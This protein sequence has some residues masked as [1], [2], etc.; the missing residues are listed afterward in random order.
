MQD[1]TVPELHEAVAPVPWMRRWWR[2]QTPGR[3]DRF[4]M[5]APL[6]A[7]LLFLAA[8]I[9][10]FWYLRL[11]EMD[12]EQEAVRRDVEYAQ[13]RLRLRLLERQEQLM[14]IARDISNKEVDPEEFIGR[15]ESMVIQ[16][17]ELQAL[18][19]IDE[20]RRIKAT[21]AGPSVPTQQQRSAGEVLGAGETEAT[22][23]L[24]RDVQQPV[25]S[26]PVAAADPTPL[27]QL[28]VPLADQA[29]F[30]GVILAEYSIDSLLRYGVLAEEAVEDRKSTRL[31]SSHQI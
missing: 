6:A 1:S 18:T 9:S 20:R 31:N 25:Y 4:A 14:R 11:E 23:S 8:I 27:L 17:P 15:G 10:A 30:G 21:Y 16:Y 26:Q 7:V 12:R 24:V 13:Q 22:F 29:R 28:H 3:Q 2:R 5:L 19:W